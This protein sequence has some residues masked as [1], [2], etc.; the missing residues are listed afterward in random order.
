MKRILWLLIFVPVLSSQSAIWSFEGGGGVV[1]NIPT[2][3]KIKQDGFPTIKTTAHYSTKPFKSPPYYYLRIGRWF[4][5]S[6]LEVELIHQKLHLNNLPPEVNDFMISNGYNLFFLNYTCL[7]H[8]FI[9]R[10]GAGPVITHPESTVRGKKFDE[11]GGLFND[12]YFF[13]GPVGQLAIA[14]RFML[15]KGLFVNLEGKFTAAWARVKI[16][17]GHANAPNLALHGD[18]GIGYDWDSDMV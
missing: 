16:A 14:H 5:H 12:G 7:F 13:S 9:F 4:G 15:Y 18:I 11:K 17:H 3:L 6:A 10:I 2:T 1:Y 8:H